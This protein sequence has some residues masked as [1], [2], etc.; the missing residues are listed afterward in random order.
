MPTKRLILDFKAQPVSG[1]RIRFQTYINGSALTFSELITPINIVNVTFEPTPSGPNEIQIGATLADTID[2]A[3]NFLNT[4][5]SGN[6]TVGT[7]ITDLGYAK[8]G[9]T[10][11]VIVASAAPLDKI[12]YWN[13]GAGP[14]RIFMR[15]DNP[16]EMY[17][18]SSGTIGATALSIWALSGPHVLKNQD[19]NT[20][21]NVTMPGN[22]TE[23][24]ERGFHYRIYST[25]QTLLYSFYVEP[26]LTDAAVLR[27]FSGDTLYVNVTTTMSV[28]YSI[29][30]SD[31][32][33][34]NTFTGLSAGSYTL[35]IKDQYGCIKQFTAVNPGTSNN[36]NLATPYQHISES[37]SIRFVERVTRTNCGGYKTV[38]NTLSCEENAAPANK[39]TQ[40]FQSCDYIRTQLLTSYE[41]VAV[42][43]G[44]TE[45]IPTKIVR[46]IGIEDRRDAYYFVYNGSLAVMFTSGNTYDYGTTN[47]NG[48]YELNGD[49]PD[50][51]TVGTWVETPFGSF[52]ISGIFIT[53]DGNRAI[54]LNTNT[55]YTG[56]NF[57]QTIYN[58]ENYD[59]WE[60]DIDMSVFVDTEF[61][62]GVKLFQTVAD[63]NWPDLFFVSELIAVRAKWA[64]TTL[65]EWSHSK[66][67]DVYFASGIT[68]RNRLRLCDVNE[69]LSDGDVDAQ[70]T[71]TAVIPI[72]ATDYNAMGFEA[73]NLTTGMK[74]KI[75]RAL[76][77]DNLKIDGLAYTLM[78]NP[79]TE[80]QGKS[81]FYKV[82][83]KLCEAGDAWTTGAQ[84]LQNIFTDAELI[85]LLESNDNEYV[86][87]N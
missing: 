50:F 8:V 57:I 7:Y 49:L 25:G 72:D 43:I 3:F 6:A 15:P 82:T 87:I 22:F 56:A 60:F 33:P 58:R 16:C 13:L 47:V 24:L 53:D 76:K 70:K 51:G 12:H 61:R 31:Y 69:S 29:N 78:E 27:Y 26:S 68:M 59:I 21:V 54:V 10:I 14:D 39:F 73:L 32:Q 75:T 17:Y 80:R 77:H 38:Y 11:E 55:N 48:T 46:N 84:D 41:N 34:E 23:L 19:L 5:Y 67:T 18:I 65:I 30:G 40:L 28:E 4:Y 64:R 83:A 2:N 45:I 86:R 81:N 63:P 1:D 85:G 79:A 66:N 52:Q 62:A 9:N 36:A 44:D 37:N 71:D 42:A 20:S 35:Y 74:R